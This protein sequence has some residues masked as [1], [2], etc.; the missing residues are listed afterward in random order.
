MTLWDKLT[1]ARALVLGEGEFNKV[2][3]LLSVLDLLL[4]FE[5]VKL[6]DEVKHN[7]ELL[8]RLN[9]FEVVLTIDAELLREKEPV[10]V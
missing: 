7:V 8:H 9:P 1:V 2:P 4:V 10:E 5:F 6:G 3:L